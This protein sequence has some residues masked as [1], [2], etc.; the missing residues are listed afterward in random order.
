MA[1]WLRRRGKDQPVGST[2]AGDPVPAPVEPYDQDEA[3]G[4]HVRQEHPSNPEHAYH[5]IVIDFSNGFPMPRAISCTPGQMA[6]LL[7]TE[8]SEF[9]LSV[10]PG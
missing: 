4:K 2:E 7:G 1:R 6:D 9:L 10:D 5:G 3:R 8:A